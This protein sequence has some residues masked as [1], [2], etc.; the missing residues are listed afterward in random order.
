MIEMFK[1]SLPRRHGT[2]FPLGSFCIWHFDSQR[3]VMILLLI[4][5]FYLHG[6]EGNNFLIDIEVN[7]QFPFRVYMNSKEQGNFIIKHFRSCD[8][9]VERKLMGQVSYA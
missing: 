1:V 3:D 8:H 4:R 5:T 2:N 7:T 9:G 6:L